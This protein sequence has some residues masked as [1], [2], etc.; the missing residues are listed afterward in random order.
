MPTAFSDVLDTVEDFTIEDQE[1]L[2]HVLEQRL[3]EDKRAQIIKDIEE[4]RAEFAAGELKP[5]SVD[6]IMSKLL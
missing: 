3:R 2:I 5:M 4:S 1:E 6:E